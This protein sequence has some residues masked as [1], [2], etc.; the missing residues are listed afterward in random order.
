MR[1]SLDKDFRIFIEK[2]G[3]VL[4]MIASE[5]SAKLET[6]WRILVYIFDFNY[7]CIYDI[8]DGINFHK[9][10]EC[11]RSLLREIPKFENFFD[12]MRSALAHGRAESVQQEEILE[13]NLLLVEAVA[14]IP[15]TIN[16]STKVLIICKQL[17]KPIDE[18]VQGYVFDSYKLQLYLSVINEFVRV[19][20]QSRQLIQKEKLAELGTLTAGVAHE[21]NNPLNTII[22]KL[23][24]LQDYVLDFKNFLIEFKEDNRLLLSKTKRLNADFIIDRLEKSI[25]LPL[26]MAERVR[27]IVLSLKRYAAIDKG[28][29]ELV[30]VNQLLDE[31][32]E[33]VWNK[34]KHK[35]VVTKN[36]D[37]NLKSIKTSPN[38]LSQVLVNILDNA[39]D[40][41]PEHGNIRINTWQD[42]K[43]T[44]IQI[45]DDG[46]GISSENLKRLF[47][48]YFTT[49]ED[50]LGI[51]LYLNHLIISGLKGSI[52][53][54]SELGK[55]TA[56]TIRLPLA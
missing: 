44:V 54:E 46:I 50:G 33:I 26:G 1:E 14:A 35:A 8:K 37:Q 22:T 34:V 24:M 18:V 43:E 20:E 48:P 53:V 2:N 51:G 56:F 29:M 49:K 21:I 17:E 32:L 4:K 5:S 13:G 40:A 31:S 45:I 25:L 10:F 7:L 16:D 47:T 52:T 30:N 11:D 19:S 27:K 6:L 23:K 42:E 38:R 9:S 12:L 41:I 3:E 15:L 28:E 55:G 36:Y 39:A